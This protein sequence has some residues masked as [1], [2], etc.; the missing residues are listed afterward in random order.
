MPKPTKRSA[1]QARKRRATKAPASP[2]ARAGAARR[3][4]TIRMYRQGIGDCFLLT[5]PRRGADDFRLVIDCGV[6]QAQP[7]GPETMKKIV[8]DLAAATQGTIDLLVL[9]H[10]HLD[11]TS[12]FIQAE[13]AWKQITV[14]EVWYAWT[15]NPKESMAQRLG[16][17]RHAMVAA[18]SGVLVRQRLAGVPSERADRIESI[19]GF[20]GGAAGAKDLKIRKAIDAL[21]SQDRVHFKSPG[22]VETF[23]GVDA[24][25][26]VLG[27]PKDTDLIKKTDSRPETYGLARLEAAFAL[28]ESLQPGKS[29]SPFDERF[30]LPLEASRSVDFFAARYWAKLAPERPAVQVPSEDHGN[31]PVDLEENGQEWR[32]IDDDWLGAPEQL[33]L[34]LDNATNNTSLVLAIE[35]PGERPSDENNPV[36]GDVLLFA[37]DAQ[38]GNWLSWQDAR[39]TVDGKTVTGPNLLERTTFYKVGHHGSGNATLKAKGLEEMKGLQVAMMPTDR[40]MAKKVKWGELPLEDLIT[41]LNEKTDRR[42]V[43]S[44]EAVPDALKGK[45]SDKNP[46][47]YEI[48]L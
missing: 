10:E 24:R 26:Y 39:F 33:A 29:E 17:K 11:H 7:N 48:E 34:K 36:K 13:D 3:R 38:V 25:V 28:V 27:P 46:L 31:A 32:R 18:L 30:W 19:L 40:A 8:A 9:T 44:D 6:H 14:K 22:D 20:F 23:D 35:L 42:L 2:T 1:P 41:R 5:F 4:V 37:A 47:Y 15:E 21:C 16:Q 45:V 12:G 43:R